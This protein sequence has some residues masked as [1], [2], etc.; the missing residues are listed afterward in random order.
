MVLETE[1]AHRRKKWNSVWASRGQRSSVRGRERLVQVPRDKLGHLKHVHAGLSF[2]DIA[3]RYFECH[4]Y[5]RRHLRYFIKEGR[6]AGA[7]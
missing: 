7:T 4:S 2:E 1:L 5:L 6:L 3:H